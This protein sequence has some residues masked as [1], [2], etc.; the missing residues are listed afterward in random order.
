MTKATH[1]GTCQICG[2]AQKLPGGNLS[3]HGYTTRW[4]WFEGTCPGAHHL[5]FEISI[6]LIEAGIADA[7]QRIARIDDDKSTNDVWIRLFHP[8]TWDR[9]NRKSC[10]RWH[11]FERSDIF[12][13]GRSV[14]YPEVEGVR[15]ITVDTHGRDEPL[16][17]LSGLYVLHLSARQNQLREYIGWQND[18]ITNWV[19][20]PLIALETVS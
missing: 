17:Y 13:T 4:G 12:V 10:Y 5:P 9:G 7:R 2:S 3:K 15:K 20:S 1:K 8:A 6:D 14:R 16:A 19:P 18:R 11:R